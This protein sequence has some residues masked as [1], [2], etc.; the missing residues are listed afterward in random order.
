MSNDQEASINNDHPPTSSDDEDDTT[1]HHS[2]KSTTPPKS[3]NP[4]PT[5]SSTTS[6]LYQFTVA[7]GIVA[8]LLH[9][10]RLRSRRGQIKPPPAS[11]AAVINILNLAPNS[12]KQLSTT[13]KL[14]SKETFNALLPIAISSTPFIYLGLLYK[15]LSSLNKDK[16]NPN[17]KPKSS[18]RKRTTFQ[19]VAGCDSAK[20]ELQDIAD[21]LKN[22]SRYTSIGAKPRELKRI[23]TSLPS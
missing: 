19:D 9:L 3:S 1:T 16:T 20:A 22:P 2:H 7:F 23:P 8:L 17:D 4:E 12:Q 13:Q 18:A 5:K 6:K 15:M 21:F 10:R 11:A 14:F